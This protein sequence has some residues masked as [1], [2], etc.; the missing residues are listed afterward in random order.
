MPAF[1]RVVRQPSPRAAATAGP[2]AGAAQASSPWCCAV[3]APIRR[4]PW[5]RYRS[6]RLPDQVALH[7]RLIGSCGAIGLARP[8]AL[9]QDGTQHPDPVRDGFQVADPVQARLLD[10]ADLDDPGAGLGHAD[11]NQGLDLEP[12]TPQHA[13]WPIAGCIYRGQV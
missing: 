9:G 11:M 4:T 12:V 10:A 3:R 6:R 5:R 8:A 2:G 7:R 13:A 1:L